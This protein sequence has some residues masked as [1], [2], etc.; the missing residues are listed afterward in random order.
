MKRKFKTD[1]QFRLSASRRGFELDE[2]V[3]PP[4]RPLPEPS[5]TAP[6][7]PPPATDPQT[8]ALVL[9]QSTEGALQAQ[10][11]AQEAR[12]QRFAATLERVLAQ[13]S[14]A[15]ARPLRWRVR[16]TERDYDGRITALDIEANDTLN[17]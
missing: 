1:E 3:T 6:P 14:F 8:L 15:Q 12:D 2:G 9:A 7:P 16:V 17:S 4:P 13:A 10:S 5:F 11:V